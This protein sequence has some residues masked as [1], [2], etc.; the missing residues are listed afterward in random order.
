MK[1]QLSPEVQILAGLAS[2]M[3]AEYT[4]ED[5][6]WIG[7]PF[8]WI[9]TRPS[10]QVGA[11]GEK[12]IAG[13][14]ATRDFNVSRSP[15][16]EADRIIESKRVE[17]K[18]STL[19][20]NGGYKFQQLRDQNYEIAICLGVS[21]FDAHC[22]ALPKSVIIDQWRNSGGLQSQH[23]GASGTDTAWLSVVPTD[24]PS[25]LTP[26][27]GSLREGLKQIAALTSFTLPDLPG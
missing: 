21:P 3:E 9:K 25:W 2:T 12:L 14:L 4:S 8:A 27:G 17:I 20:K 1:P 7:S 26:Y 22:W 13:W 11:I 10:R 6:A 16:S 5:A 15:D 18:F 24:I 23:G 19:W